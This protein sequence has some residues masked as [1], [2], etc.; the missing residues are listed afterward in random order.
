[1]DRPATRSRALSPFPICEAMN[2]WW[3]IA[4]AKRS[5]RISRMRCACVVSAPAAASC[6]T[7]SF[8][9]EILSCNSAISP[10]ARSSLVFQ[11]LN[12]CTLDF[13]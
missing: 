3:S 6:F 1:M 10:F 4:R 7:I 5:L 12:P 11:S 8:W 13:K 9:K 2:R